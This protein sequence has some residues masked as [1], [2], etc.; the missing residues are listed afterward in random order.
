MPPPA[1]H[2]LTAGGALSAVESRRRRELPAGTA[3][4]Y[5]PLQ[6]RFIRGSRTFSAPRGVTIGVQIQRSLGAAVCLDLYLV[7][8]LMPANDEGTQRT[9]LRLT[10]VF[11][12]KCQ[13]GRGR[14]RAV[15]KQLTCPLPQR[16]NLL[17]RS[18][19]HR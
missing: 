14:Q 6:C 15:L 12:G 16:K 7:G 1:A 2:E 13:P 18:E 8:E 17:G 3:R 10:V 5:T 4:Q 11:A 19:W 9:G